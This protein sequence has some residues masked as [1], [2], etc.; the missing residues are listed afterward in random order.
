MAIKFEK[1]V[2]GMILYDRHS[3]RMGNTTI[4]CVD[5]WKV[6]IVSIDPTTNTAEVQ[7][8]YNRPQTYDKRRLERLSTWSMYDED[9]E[10]VRNFIGAVTRCRKLTKKEI[11]AKALTK[12]SK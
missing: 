7:W 11:A 2:P 1:I 9:V 6:K 10:V 4:R 12:I 5:E 8:N 3:E